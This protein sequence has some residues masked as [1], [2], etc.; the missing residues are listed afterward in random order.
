MKRKTPAGVTVR[1]R[2][3]TCEENTHAT[4]ANVAQIRTCAPGVPGRG[5]SSENERVPRVADGKHTNSLCVDRSRL[6]SGGSLPLPNVV[7]AMG[8]ALVTV[9]FLRCGIV[10]CRR[11]KPCG[12]PEPA[13]TDGPQGSGHQVMGTRGSRRQGALLHAKR[14]S[15]CPANCAP[16]H[17]VRADP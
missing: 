2:S 9:R 16:S 6:D 14:V 11:A 7:R 3:T 8:S 1:G 4:E 12:I 10:V 17:R 13:T 15:G 5:T